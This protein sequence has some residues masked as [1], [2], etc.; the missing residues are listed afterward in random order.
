MLSFGVGC[1]WTKAFGTWLFA[2][3][4]ASD[5]AS[6]LSD[7]IPSLALAFE[8]GFLSRTAAFL[9][10]SGLCRLE[11]CAR[12]VQDAFHATSANPEAA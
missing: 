1:F 8:I 4:P 2:E 12:S 3:G 5:A 11:A 7:F 10:A 9:D 6:K